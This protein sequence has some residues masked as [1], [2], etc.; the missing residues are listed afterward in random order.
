MN[1][2]IKGMP[3]F[4][5]I[6][7]KVQHEGHIYSVDIHTLK[8][9]QTALNDNDFETKLKLHSSMLESPLFAADKLLKEGHYK[10]ANNRAYYAAEKAIKATL[11]TIGKDSESHNGVIK[12]FNKEFIYNACDSF[13]H[14]D[15]KKLQSLERI[16]SV[17][18][19]DDF[20]IATKEE[21]ENQ[22]K[23]AKEILEKVEIYLANRTV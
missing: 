18:D 22:V 20:Y 14:D 9:L 11:A 3:E 5:M 23:K 6:I 21:C 4:N 1:K 19:Y 8:A 12:T 10:S 7:G 16:R 2:I 15:L 17:S 13:G